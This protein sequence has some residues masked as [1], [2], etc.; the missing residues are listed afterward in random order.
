MTLIESIR[1][2]IVLATVLG[3]AACASADPRAELSAADPYEDFNR[4]MHA[5]NLALDRNLLRPVAQG[6]DA[7]TP[8][9]VQHLIG[10]GLS[11]LELPGDFAN[12]LLQGEADP[13][14][15]TLGRFTINTLIGAGGLLDPATEFG[16]P[17]EETDF[18]VTLGRFGV[19]EGAYLV[20]P[21]LGP[22]TTRDAVGSVVDLAFKPTTYLGIADPS[23]S[24]EVALAVRG[25]EAVDSRDRYGD[26]IDEVLYESADSYI[27]LRAVY[28]QR[29]RSLVA[30]EDGGAD[31]LPNIFDFN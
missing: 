5:V 24:P 8:E 18:G 15:N 21:L 30:G 11:H 25:T 2:C 13:A 31:A 16:L 28:L 1:R 4:T 26:L 17:R 23:L 14:L 3:L 7:V 29:R 10:N 20:L 19:G 6:Y 22:T 12:H 9:L 27:S